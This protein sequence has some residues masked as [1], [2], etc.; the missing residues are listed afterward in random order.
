MEFDW[1]LAGGYLLRLAVAT[2]AG[3]VI[4]FERERGGHWAGLRTHMVVALGSA[5][6]VLLGS[7]VADGDPNAGARV[8]QGV[9]AG[10][11]FL[12]AGTI[13]KLD[14]REKIKGLTTASS[15]W[16]AAAVGAVAGLGRYELMAVSV[17]MAVIVLAVLRP[18][19][20][21]IGDEEDHHRSPQPPVDLK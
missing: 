11:G 5:T 9:A 16:L 10:I 8:V 7:S 13:L 6:F 3:G 15:I 4:G 17:L 20:R 12:G 14:H 19:S 18:L 21:R 1:Q 2:M